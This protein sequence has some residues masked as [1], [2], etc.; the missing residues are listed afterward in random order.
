MFSIFE[1]SY[2]SKGRNNIA[3]NFSINFSLYTLILSNNDIIF[4]L[5]TSPILLFSSFNLS[6]LIIWSTD[7]S[8]CCISS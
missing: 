2:Q 7:C 5:G 4:L 8:S 3:I 1:T 6:M